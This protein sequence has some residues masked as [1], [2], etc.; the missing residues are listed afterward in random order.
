M[1]KNNAL[2]FWCHKILPLV[3][4]DSLS[5][6]E[7]VCKVVHKL[8]ELAE[9]VNDV[10][11]ICASFDNKLSE[12]VS[13][14]LDEMIKSG[15]FAGIVNETV[16]K[17]KVNRYT[18]KFAVFGGQLPQ[19]FVLVKLLGKAMLIDFG[20]VGSTTQFVEYCTKYGINKIDYIYITHYHEDHVGNVANVAKAVDITGATVFCPVKPNSNYASEDVMNAYE[21]S[22]GVFRSYD[23]VV[24]HPSEGDMFDLTVNETITF[25]NTDQSVYENEKYNYNNCSMC[26]AFSVNGSI[27]WIDGD[28][29]KQGQER[30]A[31]TVPSNVL[32]KQIAH[33]GYTPAGY[34]KYFERVN[35]RYTY[36]GDGA[37]FPDD[38][39]S[40]NLLSAYGYETTLC[41]RYNIPTFSTSVAPNRVL[42]FVV[43]E[44][45]FHSLTP[46]YKYER[47]SPYNT[48]LASISQGYSDVGRA[49]TIEDIIEAMPNSYLEFHAMGGWA[50]CPVQYTNGVHWRI[51]K[52]NSIN[53]QSGY[54]YDSDTHFAIAIMTE[55][56]G[57][58]SSEDTNLVMYFKSPDTGGKWRC[59]VTS[60]SGANYAYVT[61]FT[62][63]AGSGAVPL[64][65]T[66]YKG[67][68]FEM[69]DGNLVCKN[70]GIYRVYLYGTIAGNAG[71]SYRV[72]VQRDRGGTKT[73]LCVANG[74][75]TMSGHEYYSLVCPIFMERDDIVE[76][77]RTTSA[78]CWTMVHIESCSYTQ[79]V[80]KDDFL[81]T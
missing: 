73:N 41:D 57:W 60:L 43:G 40:T 33:H 12:S 31:E 68:D 50:S 53:T 6:Y 24:I 5:Y 4:D 8:N 26:G 74:V 45:Y 27:V 47:I 19:N 48:S 16:L 64:N 75:K 9:S 71:D 49:M 2:N 39:P 55:H 77:N 52:N 29:E 81:N 35:P 46:R 63:P 65:L 22:M 20:R 17:D 62:T 67:N 78:D 58:V 21:E 23:C 28:L 36:V 42:E 79:G 38:S 14:I 1:G 11:E 72:T 76:L 61:G 25:Y 59:S 30:M 34:D 37:G 15:E 70:N 80:G 69:V 56:S 54:G 32:L 18:S 10:Y 51:W 44:R 13:K 3:Y 66:N 7:T